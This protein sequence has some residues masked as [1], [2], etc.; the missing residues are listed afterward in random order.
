MNIGGQSYSLC[1]ESQQDVY[2]PLVKLE[3]NV[4]EVI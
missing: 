4:E 3:T 1:P 2:D